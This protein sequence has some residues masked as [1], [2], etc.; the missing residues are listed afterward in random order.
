MTDLVG[1]YVGERQA[2][3]ASIGRPQAVES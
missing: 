2:A 3:R 1:R